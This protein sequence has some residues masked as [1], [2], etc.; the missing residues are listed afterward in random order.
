MSTLDLPGDVHMRY[1][2]LNA[3]Q[4][5]SAARAGPNPTIVVLVPFT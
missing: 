5:E 3:T 4:P 2:R 1:E